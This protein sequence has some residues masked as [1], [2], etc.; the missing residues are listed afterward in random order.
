MTATMGNAPV[1]K[2][3]PWCTDGTGH[4]DAEEPAEQSC[5]SAEHKMELATAWEPG[6]RC[7]GYVVAHL[8]R[9]VYREDGS[10]RTTLDPPHIELYSSDTE[11]LRLSIGEARALGE[12]LIELADT[13][14]G[15]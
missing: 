3:M 5:H 2:C 13:A 7:R 9:D 1:V 4:R 12:L 10:P 15:T 8:Y 11:A 6:V 14:E